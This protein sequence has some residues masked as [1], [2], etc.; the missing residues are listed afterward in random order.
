MGP[1]ISP[2]FEVIGGRK[3]SKKKAVVETK[4]VFFLT[5]SLFA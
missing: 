2:V 3:S 4:S 5:V 1:M